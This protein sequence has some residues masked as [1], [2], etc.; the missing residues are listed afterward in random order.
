MLLGTVNGRIPFPLTF[1]LPVFMLMGGRGLLLAKTGVGWKESDG[2]WFFG[3]VEEQAKA[4]KREFRVH[5]HLALPCPHALKQ[6]LVKLITSAL[7]VREED[8]KS[9]RQTV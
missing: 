9:E 8:L 6:K 1:M 7:Y 2:G 4:W 5:S 3:E